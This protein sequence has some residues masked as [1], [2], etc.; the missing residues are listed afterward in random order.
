MYM[1]KLGKAKKKFNRGN[2]TKKV[3]IEPT[4]RFKQVQANKQTLSE[5]K[6]KN[7][8]LQVAFGDLVFNF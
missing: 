7:I 4:G 5:K 6:N 2:Y 8:K 1:V 3:T